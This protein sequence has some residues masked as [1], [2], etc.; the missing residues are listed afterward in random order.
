MV[1][2]WLIFFSFLGGAYLQACTNLANRF[3]AE[4]TPT[5]EIL[6]SPPPP[7]KLPEVDSDI[8]N[9]YAAPMAT[10]TYEKILI[11]QRVV[12]KPSF[13]KCA[14]LFFCYLLAH[15]GL[16]NAILIVFRNIRLSES[17]GLLVVA[18][19]TMG[20]IVGVSLIKVSL[21]TTW[22][23]ASVTASLMALLLAATALLPTLIL[24]TLT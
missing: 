19:L 7:Q 8:Q 9:P 12:P 22:K 14:G 13:P 17:I 5:A 15:L 2:I 10:P 1:L 24:M 6:E 23:W 4:S 3:A 21:P 20:A 11:A 16:A 18:H